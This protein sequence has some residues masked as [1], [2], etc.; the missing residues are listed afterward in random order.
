MMRFSANEDKQESTYKKY[1]YGYLGAHTVYKKV[2]RRDFAEDCLC[3]QYRSYQIY[4]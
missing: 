3:I 4:Y 1:F 2:A